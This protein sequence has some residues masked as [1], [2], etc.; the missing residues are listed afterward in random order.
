MI[1]KIVGFG[2]SW[3]YGEGLTPNNITAD[4]P[5]YDLMRPVLEKQYR[6]EHCLLGQIGKNLNLPIVNL[7][8]SGG[9][10][11]TT[12]WEFFKWYNST[13]NPS[14]YLVIIGLTADTRDSWWTTTDNGRLYM[15]S[16][17]SDKS[18]QASDH[19][20]SHIRKWMLVN[21]E[22]AEL[23]QAR[24]WITVNFF[25]S[26]CK[27][28]NIPLFQFN[29][30]NPTKIYQ[31]DSLH[32]PFE[33]TVELLNKINNSTSKDLVAPCRHPNERGAKYLADHYTKIIVQHKLI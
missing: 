23:Q 29:I 13:N 25:D 5:T 4:M 31:V 18:S 27:T 8:I 14:E 30:F 19:K 10:L 3:I 11:A 17:A 24:Y 16:S 6:H 15:H 26:F 9:S 33:N 7:G 32:D 21:S 28:H 1:K 12:Q 2:D 20:W 22:N